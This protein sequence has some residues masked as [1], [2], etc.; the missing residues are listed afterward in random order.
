[1]IMSKL[2]SIKVFSF[3]KINMRKT[4]NDFYVEHE[5]GPVACTKQGYQWTLLIT[6]LLKGP[7]L[8]YLSMDPLLDPID[9][10]NPGLAPLRSIPK[11]SCTQVICMICVCIKNTRYEI[12]VNKGIYSSAGSSYH[13]PLQVRI[14]RH[15]ILIYLKYILVVELDSGPIGSIGVRSGPRYTS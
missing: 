7:H 6:Q 2:K 1:M 5:R 4:S 12:K 9:N 13:P 11:Y 8:K 14:N 10:Q 15:Y 3:I